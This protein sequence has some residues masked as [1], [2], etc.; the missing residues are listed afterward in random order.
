[1][2]SWTAPKE[3]PF[4][5]GIRVDVNKVIHREYMPLAEDK[6]KKVIR[7]KRCQKWSGYVT[8]ARYIKQGTVEG[9]VNPR[10]VPRGKPTLVILVR[11]GYINREVEVPV[12]GITVAK[13]Q[14][15]RMFFYWNDN[16]QSPLNK[17]IMAEE[18]S[19]FPR[20]ARGK[21]TKYPDFIENSAVL[22]TRGMFDKNQMQTSQDKAVEQKRRSLEALLNQ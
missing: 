13:D 19:N 8:G 20:D 17:R 12:S 2:S 22:N 15:E 16:S 14:D 3:I 7:V 21:F 5:V 6:R 9:K 1:M 18:A 11:K 10:F 4:P